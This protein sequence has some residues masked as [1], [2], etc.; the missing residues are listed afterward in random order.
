[1]WVWLHWWSTKIKINYVIIWG[2]LCLILYDIMYLS[3]CTVTIYHDSCHVNLI[4]VSSVLGYIC[5]KKMSSLSNPLVNTLFL[6]AWYC[7][8]F[9]DIE[10]HLRLLNLSG[11]I[12]LLYVIF[13]K[14]MFLNCL[15][16][17]CISPLMFIHVYLLI[18]PRID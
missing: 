14:L 4:F 9:I 1:M 15:R 7:K 3:R 11:I 17:L 12:Y 6:F 5:D 18:P 10:N 13:F 16:V 2:K 8:S